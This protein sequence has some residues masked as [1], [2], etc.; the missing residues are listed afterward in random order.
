MKTLPKHKLSNR[1]GIAILQAVRDLTVCERRK[2]K[3]KIEM[4][5]WV[6]IKNK[7]CCVCFAGSVMVRTLNLNVDDY[8]EKNLG[9]CYYPR[10]TVCKLHALDI[11]RLCSRAYDLELAIICFYDLPLLQLSYYSFDLPGTPS[12]SDTK[13]KKQALEK[14]SLLKNIPSEIFTNPP[15][16]YKENPKAFKKYLTTIARYLNKIG[17]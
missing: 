9:T 12:N 16:K 2:D 10:K 15:P 4:R 3:Y 7:R 8:I 11:I 1:F 14:L 17:L 5:D 13:D 6:A